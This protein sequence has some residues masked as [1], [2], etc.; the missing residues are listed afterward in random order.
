MKKI[1]V[2]VLF[3]KLIS[4]EYELLKY[5]NK[6]QGEDSRPFDF[7][8]AADAL[9]VNKCKIQNAHKRLVN[10]GVLTVIR[11][12]DGVVQFCINRELYLK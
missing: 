3:N 4:F 5:I 6:I 7:A 9:G 8:E 1:D 10:S 2:Q 12:E 11:S